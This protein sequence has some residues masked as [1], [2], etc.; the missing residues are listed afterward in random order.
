MT[1]TDGRPQLVQKVRLTLLTGHLFESVVQIR[2]HLVVLNV[3]N[4][5][6]PTVIAKSNI[7]WWLLWPSLDANGG[8]GPF[9]FLNHINPRN[10][11]T[12]MCSS[13]HGNHVHPI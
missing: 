13:S 7:V 3:V 9:A 10:S 8:K 12:V 5:L 2:D 6:K 11:P 1:R 4:G